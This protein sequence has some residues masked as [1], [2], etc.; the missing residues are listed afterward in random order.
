VFATADTK[1]VF[2][3]MKPTQVTVNVDGDGLRKVNLYAVPAIV[4]ACEKDQHLSTH[5]EYHRS[6]ATGSFGPQSVSVPVTHVAASH[7]Y[8]A[9]FVTEDGLKIHRTFLVNPGF[10]AG[11]RAVLVD[12]GMDG[13][14]ERWNLGVLNVESKKDFHWKIWMMHG[15]PL[16]KEEKRP[17]LSWAV[18]IVSVLV[19]GAKTSF[20]LPFVLISGFSVVRNILIRRRNSK[21]ENLMKTASR[22]LMDT[23]RN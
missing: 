17:I 23:Y 11:Y 20:A 19:W 21:I 12:V 8:E 22:A 18:F 1:N 6:T 7:T 10:I 13:F 4:E 3:S 15:F 9:Y 14:A 2:A 16:Y 5:T